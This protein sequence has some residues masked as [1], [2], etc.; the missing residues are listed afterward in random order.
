[1]HLALVIEKSG[2]LA[3]FW[4]MRGEAKHRE[5]KIIA[6][7]TSSKQNACESIAIK[8]QL[9]FASILYTKTMFCEFKKGPFHSIQL[10]KL[11]IKFSKTLSNDSNFLE[12]K[13]DLI[14]WV[15]KNGSKYSPGMVVV[16]GESDEMP[17]F[18][19]IRFIYESSDRS[20]D[21][22]Y[23]ELLTVFRNHEYAYEVLRTD[24]FCKAI[25]Y[26]E[27]SNCFP[28]RYNKKFVMLRSF[29]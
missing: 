17:K 24:E 25:N 5:S 29:I 7:N 15:K 19:L 1:M 14:N 28:I 4:S 11:N 10:K 3:N 2:P 12:Q 6:N 27:W 8:H 18:G 20:L 9:K 26:L 22:I 23:N 16:V 21:F 13:I